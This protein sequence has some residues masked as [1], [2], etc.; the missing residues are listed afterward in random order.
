MLR[1]LLLALLLS[2]PL[3]AHAALDPALAARVHARY[4]ARD[5]AGLRAACAA[6]QG[7]DLLLCRYRL[8]P[9]TQDA[10]L[11]AG[12]PAP[13]SAAGHALA[14]GL[15]GYDAARAPMTRMMTLGRRI[16][17]HLDTA[18][19]LDAAEPLLLLIDGQGLLF[20]PAIVGGDKPKALRLFQ[21]LRQRPGPASSAD[22][23][24]VWIWYALHR[25]ERPDAAPM[26]QRLRQ[27]PL[28]PLYRAFVEQPPR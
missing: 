10:S 23:A 22:E 18:R 26:R 1:H 25:M 3:A 20:R 9:L 27:A 11:L 4:A 19:R 21:Q 16:Q 24:D 8:Y 2:T 13:Q 15:V 17:R 6:A 14:A 28:A 12:L 7:D 5:A